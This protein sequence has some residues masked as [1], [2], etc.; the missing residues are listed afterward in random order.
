VNNAEVSIGKETYFMSGDGGIS[1]KRRNDGK[2]GTPAHCRFQSIS[3]PPQARPLSAGMGG[4][5]LM[6]RLGQLFSD[7]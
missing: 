6:V 4:G 3:R 5:A 2:S 1:S 7:P